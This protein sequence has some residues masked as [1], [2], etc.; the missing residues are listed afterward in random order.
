[1]AKFEN[2]NLILNT[3]KTSNQIS[4]LILD[5]CVLGNIQI[6]YSKL[7]CAKTSSSTHQ[8][9]IQSYGCL[10]VPRVLQKLM[11]STMGLMLYHA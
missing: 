1:M 3:I 9:L 10:V 4:L 8:A 6:L 2:L 7:S 5:T 11:P